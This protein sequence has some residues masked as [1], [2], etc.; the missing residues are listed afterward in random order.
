MSKNYYA[1]AIDICADNETDFRAIVIEIAK[2][3]PSLV[4]RARNSKVWAFQARLIRNGQSKIE[5]IKYCRRMTGMGLKEAKEAV[6]A[7]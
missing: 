3:N 4:V 2:T 7:L 6:E 5:A 1:E